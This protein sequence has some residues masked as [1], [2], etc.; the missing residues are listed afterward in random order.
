MDNKKLIKKYRQ[1]R[2][3]DANSYFWSLVDK[4]S[5]VLKLGR[6][7]VYC[8]FIKEGGVYQITPVKDDFLD[9]WIQIWE[10]KDD[11]WFCETFN[12]KLEG[13]TNVKNYFGSSVYSSSEMA[14]ITDLAIQ[15]CHAQGIE[16]LT[17]KEWESLLE[18]WDK[19]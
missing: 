16:T 7:E 2:S 18:S 14:R 12:S 15:E 17:D 9:K 6:T 1:K 8:G 5:K 19:R 4:L 3:L 11:G 10:E 13:Y